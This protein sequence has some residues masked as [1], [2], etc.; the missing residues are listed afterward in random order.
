[1]SREKP[2][3]EDPPPRHF[4]SAIYVCPNCG[5]R[6]TAHLD[7][8]LEALVGSRIFAI[9]RHHARIGVFAMYV[10]REK[11][12]WNVRFEAERGFRKIGFS[13]KVFP[14]RF[15]DPR[16]VVMTAAVLMQDGFI[17]YARQAEYWDLF[18]WVYRPNSKELSAT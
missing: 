8:P 10:D 14:D 4:L 16:S 11:D 13:F 9:A 6:Y 15:D 12:C 18:D 3:K 1:M 7:V 5:R 17:Q 2:H